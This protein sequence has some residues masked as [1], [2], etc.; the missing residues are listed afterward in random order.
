MGPSTINGVG[1]AFRCSPLRFQLLTHTAQRPR[2]DDLRVSDAPSPLRRYGRDASSG[3]GAPVS[4]RYCPE[5]T[6]L[7]SLVQEYFPAFK[8]HLTAQGSALPGY[9]EQPVRQRALSFPYPLRFLFASRPARMGLVLGITPYRD[10]MTHVIFEPLAFIAR[11]AAP[12]PKPRVNLTRF[13]RRRPQHRPL[14]C[15]PRGRRPRGAG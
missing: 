12:V 3:V 10:G 15:P 7:Y 5:R 9:V 4:V 1:P 14:G 11:V 6:L 13:P 2:R 8:A